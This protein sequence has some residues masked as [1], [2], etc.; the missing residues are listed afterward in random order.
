MVKNNFQ[1][2]G[3]LGG[4][5]DPP[6]KGHLYVTKQSLKRLKLK[7]VIWAITKKNPLKKKP[8][9]SLMARKKMCLKLI[10]GNIKIQL[11]YYENKLKSKTSVSLVKY[12]KRK[13]KYK[14]YF[15]MGSD[16]LLN[17]HKWKNYKELLNMSNLV[18]FSRKGFDTKAK[19][20]VI[21]R[22]LKTKNIKF[23]KNLKID[24]SST[25]LRSKIIHGSKKN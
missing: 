18:V 12:L 4:S 11:K 20:S 21:M 10:R 17:L 24:I 14:I 2:I 19:K 15:I 8:F 22:Y 13:N 3:V 23:F 16:N 5:F 7:K 9:F 25:Q 6:H 1:N